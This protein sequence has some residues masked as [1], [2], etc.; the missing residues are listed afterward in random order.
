MV[1]Q[2]GRYR[3]LGRLGD[4]GMGLVYT[5]LDSQLDRPVALKTLSPHLAADPEFADRFLREA[6]TAAAVSHPNVVTVYEAGTADGHYFLAMELVEGTDLSE[7]IRSSRPTLPLALRIL[8]EVAA[9]LDAVHAA[10]IIH[11]DVKPENILL[12]ARERVK[13]ADFGIA[14]RADPGAARSPTTAGTP[15]YISPEQARGEPLTPASDIY[16]LACVAY[17]LLCGVPPFGRLEAARPV[18]QLLRDHVE[19]PPPSPRRANPRIGRPLEAALLRGLAKKPGDRYHTAG[20]LAGA[21]GAGHSAGGTATPWLIA[22]GA[23]LAIAAAAYLFR[24]PAVTSPDLPPLRAGAPFT[25]RLKANRNDV[26][27]TW[28]GAPV[29]GLSLSPDGVLSG[30]PVSPGA[31]SLDL[32]IRSRTGQ[33][34]R[35]TLR[36]EVRPDRVRAEELSAAARAELLDYSKNFALQMVRPARDRLAMHLIRARQLGMQA[37]Q[38]DPTLVD[39][40]LQECEA[41]FWT[42]DLKTAFQLLR[43]AERRFPHSTGVAQL[44]QRM[45][46]RL[47]ARGIQ[48]PR[49][50]TS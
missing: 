37:R 33:A 45:I 47:K 7:L 38:C 1:A 42:R 40:Y 8:R 11:G 48:V 3:I 35:A 34:T 21:L 22:A 9:G 49:G 29:E 10:G 25:T 18:A 30:T 41:V 23:S 31:Q 15:E 44:K 28:T 32:Q 46:A 6:R 12:D 24:P 26:T 4:G 17:E 13:L 27:W 14:R 2:I 5:A 36:L 19:Q 43:A 20:E 16:S 39:G 50:D